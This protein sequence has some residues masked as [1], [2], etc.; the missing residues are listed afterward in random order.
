MLLF[1]RGEIDSANLRYPL[2]NMRHL[3]AK[4]L[5]DIDNR[6]QR[7]LYRIVQQSSYNCGRINL[8]FCQNQSYFE[9]VNQIGLARRAGLPGMIFLGIFISLSNDFQ[10]VG[11]AVLPH[12]PHQFTESGHRERGGR[13]LFPQ[14]RHTGL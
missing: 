13:D 1:A 8:H 7:I 3:L 5:A 6:D 12:Q 2:D 11:R 10:I 4:F 9:R 14:S